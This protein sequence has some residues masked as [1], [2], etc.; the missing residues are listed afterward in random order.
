MYGLPTA[1]ELLTKIAQAEADKA[2]A[3]VSTVVIYSS[4]G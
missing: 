3:A 2:S 4:G 1:K